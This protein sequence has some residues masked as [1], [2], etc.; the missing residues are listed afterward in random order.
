MILQS[1]AD[2][3]SYYDKGS[4]CRSRFIKSR[5]FY[6]EA[7]VQSKYGR[8]GSGRP[9]RS[10]S[11]FV[12]KS[13][14]PSRSRSPTRPDPILSGF[15][16]PRDISPIAGTKV[17]RFIKLWRSHFF[18]KAVIGAKEASIHATMCIVTTSLCISVILKGFPSNCEE[19][20]EVKQYRFFMT[21][22]VQ[23]S[24]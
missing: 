9:P 3:S 12:K 10:L 21:R 14:R 8:G 2:G 11:R 24:K 23:A 19:M 5:N 1:T 22:M 18:I 6:S 7:L 13:G 20:H 15:Y 4:G 17:N 16:P